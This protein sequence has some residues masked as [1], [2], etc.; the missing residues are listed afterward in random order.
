MKVF[1]KR[2][3]IQT[4]QNVQLINITDTVK[5]I[6]RE[7]HILNGMALVYTLHTTTGLMI[8]EAEPGLEKDF[9]EILKELFPETIDNRFHHHYHEKDGRM[10]VNAWAHFRS[11]FVGS[12][13]C[14]P[15][16]NGKLILGGRQ[17]IY[18]VEM[19]GPLERTIV[20]QI[21]GE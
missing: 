18:L 1:L 17:D 20:I 8:N 19:D 12:N 9:V 3:I 7:S 21:M 15:I 11:V 16:Q 2:I 13:L 10:A 6:V 14:I 4:E 5:E